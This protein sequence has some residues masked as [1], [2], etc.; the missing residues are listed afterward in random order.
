[1]AD[2]QDINSA[3][4]ISNYDT[5]FES[6]DDMGLS[7]ELL[8]GIYGYGFESPSAIQQ[9]GIVPILGDRD[10]IAQAQSG[11]G[12][13][14]TFSIGILQKIDISRTECQ[15]LILVPT[16]ELATQIQT[17]INAIGSR[18]NIITHCCVGGIPI[19]EDMRKLQEGV[20]II[21]GTPGRVFDMIDRKYLPTAAIKMFCLDEADE[22]LSKGFSEQIYEVFQRLPSSVQVILIS[23]TIP[24]EVLNVAGN[25]MRDPIKIMVKKDE[26]TLEGIKQFYIDVEDESLKYETLTDLYNSLS[27]TQAIIFCNTKRSVMELTDRLIKQDFTVSALHSDL[28]QE[29]RNNI[30]KDFREGRSRVLVCTDLLARGFDVQQVSVVINFDFPIDKEKYLHRIGRSGRFGRKGVAVNFLAGNDVP[31]MKEIEKHY[32]TQIEEMPADIVNLF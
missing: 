26:L 29:E 9:R 5:V 17:V 23:A 1:M 32:N 11:T 13:T 15:A 22:M 21:V 3:E 18:L 16:R 4:I 6:F 10:V 20:H 28:S 14:A 7:S 2:L 24:T 19:S 30:V 12:K 31:M 25:F 27:I 8:R